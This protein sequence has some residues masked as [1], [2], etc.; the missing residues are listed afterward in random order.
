MKLS[1]YIQKQLNNAADRAGK[2]PWST[3]KRLRYS[4]DFFSFYCW[5][6]VG[7]E[8]EKR[9]LG[10]IGVGESKLSSWLVF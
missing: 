6:D 5:Y 10:K 9:G 1:P 7:M 4:T 3:A 8:G 2:A